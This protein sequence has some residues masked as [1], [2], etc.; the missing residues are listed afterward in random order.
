MSILYMF[1]YDNQIVYIGHT[2]NFEKRLA[3]H[4]SCLKT[5]PNITPLY[6]FLN[7]KS[8]TFNDIKFFTIEITDEFELKDLLTELI[9]EAQPICN[10]KNKYPESSYYARNK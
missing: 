7:E 4:I 1:G 6:R 10:V 9:K 8:L 2:N 5:K 3:V